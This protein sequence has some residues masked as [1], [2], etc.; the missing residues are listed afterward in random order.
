[1]KRQLIGIVWILVLV[2]ST[3][4]VIAQTV[5]EGPGTFTNVNSTR[6]TPAVQRTL[7]AAAGNITQLVIAGETIT[8][9]W[10]GVF[11]NVTGIITLDNGQNRTMYDW[12][13]ANPAGEIY[14]TTLAS[15]NWS[16]VTCYNLTNPNTDNY[17]TKAEFESSLGLGATDDD[18]VDE[19]FSDANPHDAFY[20]G[21]IG[22]TS[23]QCPATSM[24]NSSQQKDTTRFQ[25][26]LLYNGGETTDNSSNAGRIIY[27]ALLEDTSVNGFDGTDMDF[28][29]LLG[30]NGHQ[31]D[32][33][34]T[35][36][37]FYVELE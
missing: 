20:V 11:G 9:T 13:V 28:Q 33:S 1:M 4:A 2:L 25:E 30:E 31:G 35:P 24:Y 26:V 27:T 17:F 15:V 14:A 18:G 36:Y 32:T 7:N 10:F 5:P 37:Y 8:Q 34:T 16:T 23:G 29:M 6:R 19:T 3:Y 21:T 22:F 12:N